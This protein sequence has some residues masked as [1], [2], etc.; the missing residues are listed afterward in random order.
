MLGD[1]LHQQVDARYGMQRDTLREV[2]A[3]H[4]MLGAAPEGHQVIMTNT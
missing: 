2:H 4:E 1:I 3:F